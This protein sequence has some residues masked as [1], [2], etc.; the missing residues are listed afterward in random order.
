MVA[1][2]Q[3]TN[4]FCQCKF[5]QDLS[6][7]ILQIVI[8]GAAS[9]WKCLGQEVCYDFFVV[10]FSLASFCFCELLRVQ[11]SYGLLVKAW[12]VYWQFL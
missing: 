10:N 9:G 11:L 7:S 4:T 6:V 5:M 3:L 1:A 2:M 8:T 12:C